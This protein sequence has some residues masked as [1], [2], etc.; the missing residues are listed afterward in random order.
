[1]DK[2]TGSKVPFMSEHPE[3]GRL[4]SLDIYADENR[5]GNL[6]KYHIILKKKQTKT[7]K[8][9]YSC[10]LDAHSFRR[11]TPS[12]HVVKIRRRTLLTFRE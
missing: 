3:F 4:N 9:R 2:V 8:V 11:K 1:M 5:D 12:V 10:I 7:Q 6:M